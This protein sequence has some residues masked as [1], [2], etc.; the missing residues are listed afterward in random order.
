MMLGLFWKRTSANAFFYAVAV[1]TPLALIW[2]LL[3]NPFG[4]VA[5]IP[6]A[7]ATII[8]LVVGSLMSKEPVSPGYLQYKNA[9]DEYKAEQ[10]I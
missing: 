2:Y 10:K 6:S 3:G 9:R 8:I 1:G 4:I 5:F 7:A